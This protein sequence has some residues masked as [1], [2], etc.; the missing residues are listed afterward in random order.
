MR[1]TTFSFVLVCCA[2]LAGQA[3]RQL[4]DGRGIRI[5]AAVAPNH[6]GEDAYAS[7]LAREFN[8]AEP[9]NAMKFG[10]IH[11]EPKRYN[12]GPAEAVV[13]FA[14]AHKM[15]VRGHT[16][17]WHNQVAPWVKNGN[18]TPE[19]L[20]GILEEHIQTVVGHFAGKVYAWDVVNEAFNTDGSLRKTVWS[21]VPGYIEKAFQWAHAADPKALLFYNDYSAEVENRKS[22]AIFLMI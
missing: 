1:W 20:A 18:F 4:A 22:D 16:L 10:P 14:Q 12:F 13:D 21:D 15:A 8:Q 7:T 3:L 17:V 2:P 5:G 11:P 9:E 19:Q 6:L